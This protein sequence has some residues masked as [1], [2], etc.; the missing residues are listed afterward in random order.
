MRGVPGQRK[1]GE[2]G[3]R[4]GFIGSARNRP[5]VWMSG[6][7]LC[8]EDLRGPIGEKIDQ[9]EIFPAR[10]THLPVMRGDYAPNTSRG[11]N[12]WSGL[13][14]ANM[15]IQQ[16]FQAI[17]RGKNRT[18]DDIGNDYAV[19]IFQG[20]AAG[21]LTGMNG[22]KEFQEGLVKSALNVDE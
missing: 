5:G 4:G 17:A 22:V 12:E 8:V 20:R 7:K 11:G 14:R 19:C 18:I 3:A 2:S 16:D 15:R 1:D 9:V 13:D 21:G 10:L 6:A